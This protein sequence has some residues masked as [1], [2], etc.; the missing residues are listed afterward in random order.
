MTLPNLLDRLHDGALLIT[1][2]DRLDVLLAALFAH[3]LGTLPSVAGI[4]LTGGLRP[5]DGS[6]ADRRRRGACRRS[7]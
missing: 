3:A 5:P 6:C 4:V 7:C 1:P 2:G